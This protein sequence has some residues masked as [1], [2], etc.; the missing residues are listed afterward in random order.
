M[1]SS[2]LEPE[3]RIAMSAQGSGIFLQLA[4]FGGRDSAEIYAER[5]RGELFWLNEALAVYGQDNLF[6]VQA[7]P[8]ATTDEARQA[9]ERIGL[10][11][12]LKP[13]VVTK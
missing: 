9:A 10:A 5:L 1:C 11:L 8:F 4:A 3:R 13:V 2:D 6:R 12:G 7:G